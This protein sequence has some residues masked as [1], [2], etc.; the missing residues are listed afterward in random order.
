MH[1]RVIPADLAVLLHRLELGI[2]DAVVAIKYRSRIQ[3]IDESLTGQ[4]RIHA[5]AAHTN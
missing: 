1:V 3:R 2:A 4:R 5:V